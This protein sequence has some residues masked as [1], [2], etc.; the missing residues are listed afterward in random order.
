MTKAELVALV[1]ERTAKPR[2][3][4]FTAAALDD[5]IKDGLA[6]SG[7]RVGNDGRRPVY[8]F[9]W[10]DL[11]R[12]TFLAAI[13]S[14]GVRSRDALRLRLFVAGCRLPIWEV[15]QALRREYR[16][17]IASLNGQS[18]TAYLDNRKPL[19]P[20]KF[21]SVTRELGRADQ[22][23]RDA[24]LETPPE[25]LIQI[26][27]DARQEPLAGG[28][29]EISPDFI[30][31]LASGKASMVDLVS[32][33]GNMFAG[34]FQ[35][36]AAPGDDPGQ[37]DSVDGLI[38]NAD[39]AAWECVPS[40]YRNMAT[41]LATHGL[42]NFIP[43]GGGPS[44]VRSVIIRTIKRSPQFLAFNLVLALRMATTN[45][46]KPSIEQFEFMNWLMKEP[47]RILKIQ[48]ANSPDEQTAIFQNYFDE[49][50]SIRDSRRH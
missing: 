15:R 49:F 40:N 35:M 11:H 21:A 13:Q 9:T 39:D 41:M 27:R 46:G 19:T 23:L 16:D 2:G 3:S 8:D 7:R 29:G 24:G 34:M 25:A 36:D 10:R 6:P 28:I 38:S 32:L 1:D 44:G 4:V 47:G 14:S 26:V 43:E 42:W 45:P 17:V 22:I 48:A 12:V 33:A 30:A 37:I 50:N 20:A 18:R 5:L 31:R